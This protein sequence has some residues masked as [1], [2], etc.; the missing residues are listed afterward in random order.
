MARKII[1]AMRLVGMVMGVQNPV[2]PIR[3]GINKLVAH[4]RRRIN[5]QIGFA[6]GT[7]FSNQHRTPRSPVFRVM[8]VAIPPVTV[9]AGY[10]T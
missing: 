3:T 8:G 4:I 10:T 7:G 5:K 6:I 9:N 1:N 2:Q